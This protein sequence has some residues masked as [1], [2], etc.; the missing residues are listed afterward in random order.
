MQLKKDIL[1]LF[2]LS[3]AMC[4]C[5]IS[6]RMKNKYPTAEHFIKKRLL[7]ETEHKL[8]KTKNVDGWFVKWATPQLWVN[9]MACNVDKD[10]KSLNPHIKD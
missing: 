4:F 7:T 6:N 5:R 2:L 8:L 9:R 1:R 3:Y 10:I